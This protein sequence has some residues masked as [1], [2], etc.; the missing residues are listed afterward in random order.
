MSTALITHPACLLH[1]NGPYHPECPDRLRAVLRI[2]EAEEFSGLLRE[3]APL[4]TVEQ[5]ARVHPRDYIDAILAVYARARRDRAARRRH[6]HVQRQRRS[7][8]ARGGRRGRG[9]GRRDGR[10]GARGVRGRCARPGTT[11][12]PRDRWGS[13]CSTTRRWRPSTRA[14]GGA[15]GA[16]RSW[17]S[18]STTATA[19]KP[20]SSRPR[21]LLRLQSPVPVLS[22][23]RRSLRTRGRPQHRQRRPPAGVGQRG[24]PRSLGRHDPAGARRLRPGTADRVGGLRRP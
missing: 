2:L 24:I 21:S 4:A 18:T 19:R 11:P 3:Q 1:D 16:S 17:I 20:C 10:M 13:A 14:P 22:R 15:S 23:H 5:L 7:R 6:R 9:G 8:P 12:S